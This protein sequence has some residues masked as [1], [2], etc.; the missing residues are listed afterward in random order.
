MIYPIDSPQYASQRNRLTSY[1]SGAPSNDSPYQRDLKGETPK[2]TPGNPFVT[3]NALPM[4]LH[5]VTAL[6]WRDLF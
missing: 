4:E 6:K 1:I 3:D 5:K 2:R